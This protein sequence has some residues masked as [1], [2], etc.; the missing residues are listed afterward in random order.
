MFDCIFI[1]YMIYVPKRLSSITFPPD[2][3]LLPQG[4][5]GSRG[6]AELIAI[7]KK[8]EAGLFDIPEAERL[9]RAWQDRYVDG[10]TVS[11]K[12]KQVIQHWE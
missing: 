6:Q 10:S 3:C 7:Q 9:F 11:F 2:E 8:V 5:G 12:A 1:I 4:S